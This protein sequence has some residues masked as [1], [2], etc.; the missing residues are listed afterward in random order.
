MNPSIDL[1]GTTERLI[2]NAKSRCRTL[3]REPGGG[4]INV[5]RNLHRLGCPVTAIFTAGGFN[6]DLLRTMVEHDRLSFRCTQIAAETRQN[7][8]ISEG[9]SGKLFHFVFSGP[10]MQEAEWRNC[11]ASVAN[12]SPAPE[13]LV[14]SGSLPAGVPDD[15]YWRIAE[16][17]T[18]QGTRVVLD[19][20]GR[21]LSSRGQAS[22][23]LAKLNKVEFAQLGYSG[24]DD[25]ESMLS[26]MASMVN[27]G[28]AEALI[29]TLDADG[30]LLVASSG[31]RC[32]FRPPATEVVGHVGAGDSFV[33]LL[34]HKLLS[35]MPLTAAFGYGI[36]A[37]A[38]KVAT[39][40]NQLY[41]FDAVERMYR[42]LMSG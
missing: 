40:G 28:V 16:M 13:Y 5:A 18:R 30:A 19:A 6:G 32:H 2:D 7:V 17:A 25:H 34:V 42:S 24:P 21:A 3:S 29:V 14:L 10:Q 38:V 8:A 31:E 11:L 35:G 41:D 36:A 33:A 4:G 9:C 22:V 27:E 20:S 37:A 15:F 39:T 23:F 26:G 1:F 12:L